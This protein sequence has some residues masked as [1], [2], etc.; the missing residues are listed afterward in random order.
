MSAED[1]KLASDHLRGTVGTELARSTAAFGAEDVTV[2]K[3]HGIYQQ[4]D[5]DTRR[6]RTRAGDDLDHSCMVRVG[7]PGGRLTSEQWTALDRVADAVGSDSLRVTTRQGIQFHGVVK[8]HLKPLLAGIAA[9]ELSTFAACGDVVRNVMASPAPLPGAVDAELARW[10]E[11]IAAHF[12]PT[13]TAYVEIWLDEERAISVEPSTEPIYGDA[14][15]PRKFKIGL[16]GPADNS[17]DVLTH[18]VGIVPLVRDDR[19]E[20]FTLAIGGGMGRSHQ[21]PDD[22][23]PRLGSWFA[24]VAPQELLATIEAIVTVHRDVGDRDDRKQARLKYVVDRLGLD[25][26]RAE[27]ERRVGRTLRP[28]TEHRFPVTD[29]HLGWHRANDGSWFVGVHLPSGRVRDLA[30]RRYRTALRRIASE[31]GPELRCTP[32]QN[33]LVCGVDDAGRD[34]IEEL[35]AEHGVPRV[36][37]LSPITREALACPALPTC[38]QALGEAERILPDVLEEVHG[39]LAE[40]GVADEPLQLRMT[41]CPNGCAR[42]Y[43]AELALVGRTKTAYDIF[44]GGSA[45][46]T[47]LNREVAS[48]VRRGDLVDVLR[49]LLARWVDERRGSERFGDWFDRSADEVGAAA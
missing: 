26:V 2:L 41:G 6:E 11:R 13:T 38:G 47:R 36:E 17:V 30:D 39:L 12:R 31:V 19:I 27:V 22:T 34:R 43:V 7:L 8:P 20:G 1:V 33:V 25:A 16:A 49:P 4:D 37:Q 14:Y 3:F 28:P 46:G 35:L 45:D 40:L 15:L 21:R 48:S 23:Y 24:D 32:Q 44:A 10:A 29:D 9:A 42:P 18:D 5:R